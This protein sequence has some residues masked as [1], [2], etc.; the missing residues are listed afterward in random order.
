MNVLIFFGFWS[1][2]LLPLPLGIAW[3]RVS[4]YDSSLLSAV[5]FK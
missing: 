3:A 2:L 5:L 4:S 1:H